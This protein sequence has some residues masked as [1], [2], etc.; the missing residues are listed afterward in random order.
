MSRLGKGEGIN[1]RILASQWFFIAQISL[2]MPFKGPTG[3]VKGPV[4]LTW[5][6]TLPFP[7]GAGNRPQ[8]APQARPRPRPGE[9]SAA[10]GPDPGEGG[11]SQR[12]GAD[13]RPNPSG[14]RDRSGPPVGLAGRGGSRGAR[15]G[16]WPQAIRLGP[17]ERATA[18]RMGGAFPARSGR[19]RAG[20]D[21]PPAAGPK[22]TDG[23]RPARGA[24][25][26][27]AQSI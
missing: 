9:R 25:R 1:S 12:A 26:M 22:R 19:A 6:L 7:G 13:R 5:P 4:P 18:R 10:P 11:P 20:R 21:G 15:A 24:Q 14:P 17:E 23:R 2:Q 3:P 16:R 27:R 8:G